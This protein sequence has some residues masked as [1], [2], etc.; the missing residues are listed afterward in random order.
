ML[1]GAVK[2]EIAA[3]VRE[4]HTGILEAIGGLRTGAESRPEPHRYE[5]GA[6]GG[7]SKASG[8]STQPPVAGSGTS[9]APN[10]TSPWV[11]VVKRGRKPKQ[12][13][14]VARPAVE[15]TAV[16]KG[17]SREKKIAAL[18]QKRIPRTSAVI[19]DR[20]TGDGV[21]ILSV[22][23]RVTK[24]VDLQACGIQVK[25]AKRSRAGGIIL[26]VEDAATATRL[27]E[28]LRTSVKGEA[29]VRLPVR[30]T[31]V[32]LVGVPEWCTIRDV[33]AGLLGAGLTREDYSW[34]GTP[35]IILNKNA[36]GRGDVVA[37]VDV[38]HEA[39]LNL[40]RAGTVG[41]GW[42]RSKVKLLEKKHFT[43]F[44]C[45]QPGHYAVE[46][47]ATTEHKADEAAGPVGGT[48]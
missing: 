12:P 45:R 14:A 3:T 43:C 8:Q 27:A 13:G 25:N 15:T 34:E 22:M 18:V 10:T 41:V 20:P 32:L 5:A 39:A 11:E 37:R 30:S 17:P 2:D 40:H 19:I 6:E 26:E 46:C 28:E 31:P 29:R 35:T 4:A 42:T 21:T 47:K 16:R 9:S 7:R 1:L 48:P 44:R 36:G 38:P 33:E 24:E 23:K